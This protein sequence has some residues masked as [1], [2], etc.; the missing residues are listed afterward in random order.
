MSDLV[1]CP[2]CES[3]QVV[4][5]GIK[6]S[7]PVEDIILTRE[8]EDE[9]LTDLFGR[10]N[11]DRQCLVCGHKWNAEEQ[12]LQ[13]QEDQSQLDALTFGDRKGKFYADYEAGQLDQARQNVPLEAA[14]VYR[15]KGVKATYRFLKL[16]DIKTN[17]FKKKAA[18]AVLGVVLLLIVLI[19]TL[20]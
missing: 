15:R 14:G 18:L 8:K 16:L 17:R 12:D 13:Q 7:T 6:P 10:D 2:K 11:R 4:E 3:N 19:Y 9:V 5:L 1:V 20:M